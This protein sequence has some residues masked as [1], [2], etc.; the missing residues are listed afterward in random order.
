[1]T[2]NWCNHIRENYHHF[3]SVS[4]MAP[5]HFWVR[6]LRFPPETRTHHW[7]SDY[8]LTFSSKI[9]HCFSQCWWWLLLLLLL[10]LMVVVINLTLQYKEIVILYL[11]VHISKRHM[12]QITISRLPRDSPLKPVLFSSIL[13]FQV[14][15]KVYRK[16]VQWVQSSCISSSPSTQLSLFISCITVVHVSQMMNRSWYITAWSSQ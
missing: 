11:N 8:P 5:L 14:I 6:H 10:F 2:K 1:M 13:L 15:F 7:Y 12:V 9:W 3:I 4:K 16:T